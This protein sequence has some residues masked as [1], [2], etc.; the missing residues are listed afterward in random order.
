[1]CY[2]IHR[3][4]VACNWTSVSAGVRQFRKVL[5]FQ[6]AVGLLVHEEAILEMVQAC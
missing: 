3:L 2:V 1:M 5:T 4:F 6:V